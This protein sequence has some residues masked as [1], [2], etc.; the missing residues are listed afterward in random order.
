MIKTFNY[1]DIRKLN[2]KL[3]DR[4]NNTMFIQTDKLWGNNHNE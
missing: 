4:L 3:K 2:K 1:N